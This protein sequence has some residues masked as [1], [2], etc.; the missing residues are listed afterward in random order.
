MVI[1]IR[2]FFS[3]LFNLTFSFF[4]EEHLKNIKLLLV[5][6]FVLNE[7]KSIDFKEEHFQN[8]LLILVTLFILNEDKSIISKEEHP[9]NI[10]SY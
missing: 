8:I 1:Y 3:F 10:P 7:D 9:L 2:F 5:T 6:F 4:K